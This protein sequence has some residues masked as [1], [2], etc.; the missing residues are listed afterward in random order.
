MPGAKPHGVFPLMDLEFPRAFQPLFE[1]HRY[2]VYYGGRGS[3]KS[4]AF[5][6]A[7][8][9]QS[10]QRPLRILCA[11]EVQKSIKDSV[12]KL[13][14]DQ[15]QALGL[16]AFF[17]V[18]E[19][20]IRG[21]NGSEFAFAGLSSH[22]VESVK[23]FEGIDIVWIEE[24][25]TVSKK[26]WDILIPTIRKDGSEIWISFNPALDTDETYQRFVQ[27]PPQNSVVRKVNYH[28]NPWFP[29]VL[30]M[31][32]IQCMERN[33]KDYANIWEG[34]CKAAVDGAIYA[35]EIAAVRDSGRIC[36]VPA[37]PL[38][39]THVVFD[40]GWNDSMSIILAQRMGS[41]LR[42]IEYIEDDH[43]TLDYYS[44]LLR[45]RR[46]NWGTVFLPHDG[47]SKDYKTGKSA[48]QIMEALG[49]TVSII[50]AASVEQQ[51][52][53]T[54]RMAFPRTVF[55]R[56]NTVRLVECL[57]RYK[58]HIPTTT[59][60]PGAP[61][62]D[63]FSH[64]ADCYRYTCVAADQMSNEEWGGSMSYPRMNYA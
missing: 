50:P 23:S 40:L 51:I 7:L 16:G 20:A 28:D 27:S 11:R 29:Q 37:D 46:H 43:K 26:S 54:V 36:N 17:E 39:K 4:W 9:I 10:A 24:G 47:D 5:A 19:T 41:E 33:P 58:R 52:Q 57:K 15:I 2:K 42:I 31:E 22:T 64:G 1:P 13:L 49:W 32:R 53:N 62:H 25:Q 18:T 55:D 6:R 3:G 35:D 48:K 8:L 56:L 59:G 60:E 38:L 21:R 30:E 61:V 12:H 44:A 63:E 45:E 34:A 14:C